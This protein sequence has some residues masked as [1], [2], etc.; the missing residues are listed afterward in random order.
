MNWDRTG[1]LGIIHWSAGSMT[2]LV[3]SFIFYIVP[4]EKYP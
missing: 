4:L 1:I 2:G 3:I